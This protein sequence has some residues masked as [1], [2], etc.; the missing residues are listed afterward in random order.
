MNNE[1]G[2]S[3]NESSLKQ[4]SASLLISS[5][6]RS[7][8]KVVANGDNSVTIENS[9]QQVLNRVLSIDNKSL[10]CHI[11]YVVSPYCYVRYGGNQCS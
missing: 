7:L 5:E 11:L 6:A 4:A 8:G 9:C 2:V 1:F 3:L 10:K